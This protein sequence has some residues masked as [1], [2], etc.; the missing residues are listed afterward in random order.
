MIVDEARK[1]V[2]LTP[3]HTAS[4]N[5]HK[6]LCQPPFDCRWICGPNPAGFWDHHVVV[7]PSEWQH[8]GRYLVVRNPMTQRQFHGG[9]QSAR[10]RLPLAVCGGVMMTSS[11]ASSTI[12]S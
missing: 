10:C 1:L 3:P 7:V 4:R 12:I 5:L 8:Y 11:L 2:I 6:A 9:A